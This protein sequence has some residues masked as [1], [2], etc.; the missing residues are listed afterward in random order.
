MMLMMMMEQ[1]E[2]YSLADQHNLLLCL[3]LGWGMMTEQCDEVSPHG[4][5]QLVNQGKLLVLG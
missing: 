2:A 1:D 5:W 3:A 4:H